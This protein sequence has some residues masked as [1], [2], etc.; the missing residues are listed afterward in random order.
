VLAGGLERDTLQST[1]EI[2]SISLRED[3]H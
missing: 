2:V 3:A 1:G